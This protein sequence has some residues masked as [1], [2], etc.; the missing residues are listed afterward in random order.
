MSFST[1][2]FAQAD[3]LKTNSP[4]SEWTQRPESLQQFW[5][6]GGNWSG[7]QKRLRAPLQLD[8][9]RRQRVASAMRRQYENDQ[10]PVSPALDIFEQGA[11]VVTTGHQLQA[12]GGP[13]YFHY[14]ILS[15][16]RWAQRLNAEG[17][18]AVAVFWMAS[19]DHDFEEIQ[20]TFGAV[21]GDFKWEPAGVD[22][23]GPVGELLWDEHAERAWH[24][25][26]DDN[27]IASPEKHLR[28]MTLAA[29]VRKWVAE[30]FGH[31]NILVIDGHDPELKAMAMHLWQAEWE[32]EG[33][34]STVRK[35][36]DRF[37]K[38]VGEVQIQPRDNNL[39]VL[40]DEGKR[41]R[42]D[43]WIDANGEEA[44]RS[45]RPDQNSPNVALRPLYQEFLLQSIAFIG[46]PSEVSYWMLLGDAFELHDVHPPALLVRDGALVLNE[47]ASE[48]C[49]LMSWN[50]TK[51]SLRGE[52]AVNAWADQFL[53]NE[54]DLMLHFERWSEAMENYAKG[55]HESAL[56]TTRATLSKMEKELF[57]VKKKWRK[58]IKQQHHEQCTKIAEVY[59]GWIFPSGIP[60]ERRLSALTLVNA[61]GDWSDF[62]DHWCQILERADEPQFLVFQ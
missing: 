56:P 39:F 14:K 24:A 15:A 57:A 55:I 26:A 62:T 29:R 41:Q 19:E 32:N 58:I 23:K 53:Q 7:I 38:K 18:K 8:L 37:Q 43:R 25:W 10:V 54:G 36:A 44:W 35:T 27:K 1:A 48:V 21:G 52:D 6:W 12:G 30:W 16:I 31:L 11:H 4:A 13:A 40:T 22:Q 3:A 47:G 34:G 60:Q 49:E 42:A 45:L 20:S 59:D 28:T 51:P 61:V 17:E 9:D 46:G 33:I 50:P 5:R 2:Q